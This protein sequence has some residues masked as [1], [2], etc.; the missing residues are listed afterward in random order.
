MHSNL[1]RQTL[2]SQHY[3]LHTFAKVSSRI[4]ATMDIARHRVVTV[5][6]KIYAARQ[7]IALIIMI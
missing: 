4:D 7:Q 1:F 3:L 6:Q 5:H 2:N